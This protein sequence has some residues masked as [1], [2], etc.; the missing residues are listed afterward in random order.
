MY[1]DLEP[2]PEYGASRVSPVIGN[3]EVNVVRACSRATRYSLQR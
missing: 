3:S 2:R 1:L